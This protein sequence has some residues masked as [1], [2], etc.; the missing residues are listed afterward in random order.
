MD[1]LFLLGEQFN[2]LLSESMM[3]ILIWFFYI[4]LIILGVTFAVLNAGDVQ[5][6]LYVI[7][8]KVPIAL[9]MASMIGLGLMLGFLLSLIRYWRLKFE[10]NKIKHQLKISSKEIKNLRDI[11]LKDQH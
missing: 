9:L 8:L 10:L 11:P 4:V 6:N 2:L 7:S 3:R 5:V 1:N